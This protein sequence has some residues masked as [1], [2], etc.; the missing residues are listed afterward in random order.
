[1]YFAEKNKK[2][3]RDKFSISKQ[4]VND[5]RKQRANGHFKVKKVGTTFTAAGC[6]RITKQH[7]IW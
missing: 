7:N 1:V 5:Q 6:S 3:A 2:I 4:L